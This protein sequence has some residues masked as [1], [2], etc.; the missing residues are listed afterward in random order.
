MEGQSLEVSCLPKTLC[1]ADIGK[2]HRVANWHQKTPVVEFF[3]PL[4]YALILLRAN[5]GIPCVFYGDLYGYNRPDGSGFVPPPFGSHILPRLV[6][7][8][9]L[10]AYGLQIDYFDDP[11]CI[12]FTRLGGGGGGA[13]SLHHHHHHHQDRDQPSPHAWKA[14]G[15]AVLMTNARTYATKPMFVGKQHAGQRWTDLL[16]GCWGDV[17]IDTDGWGVFAAGPRSVAVWAHCHAPRR[18]EMDTL[19]L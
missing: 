13:S 3:I 11:H 12:G 6:L 18:E 10:Y 8:R 5:C 1:T 14:A 7:A 16:G 19:V 4:A 15:L 2:R 17:F 9:K